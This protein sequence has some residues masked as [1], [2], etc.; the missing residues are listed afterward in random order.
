ML[1]RED[2]VRADVPEERIAFIIMFTRIGEQETK[3][4]VTSNR[5]TLLR[6]L[7]NANDVPS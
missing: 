6:L 3:L 5:F 1:R 4:A 7:V 2:L